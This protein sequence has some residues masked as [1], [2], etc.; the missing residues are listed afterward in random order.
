MPKFFWNFAAS[1]VGYSRCPAIAV[2]ASSAE[3]AAQLTNE[4]VRL[5]HANR[6]LDEM[7]VKPWLPDVASML[8]DAASTVSFQ[9]VLYLN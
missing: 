4:D 7:F 3:K 8:Q 1:N 2:A 5:S 6:L 9:R